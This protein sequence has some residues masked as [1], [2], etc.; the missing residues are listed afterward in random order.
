MPKTATG[1]SQDGAHKTK[2]APWTLAA[3]NQAFDIQRKALQAVLKEGETAHV[4]L[5]TPQAEVK[6]TAHVEI[7]LE[8]SEEPCQRRADALA[9][10]LCATI[11]PDR[12]EMPLPDGQCVAFSSVA[13]EGY[14]QSAHER[15]HV[16]TTLKEDALAYG[17]PED[18]ADYA[19][20]MLM[21]A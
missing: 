10:A 19:L 4:R 1:I 13:F 21:E 18:N 7:T 6:P 17:C 5:M 16:L 8:G 9:E 14:A 3:R 20:L 12:F 2:K 15:L 11:R